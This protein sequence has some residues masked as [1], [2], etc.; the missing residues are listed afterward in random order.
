MKKTHSKSISLLS[1]SGLFIILFTVGLYAQETGKVKDILSIVAYDRL[2]TMPDTYLIDVRTRAEYQF[3]GHPE[4]AYLFPFKF[5]TTKLAKPGEEY[6]Y[7]FEEN[8]AFIEEISK[9]FKKEENLIII[10]RDGKRSALAAKELV[11]NGFEN[12]FNVKDGFEGR[13]FPFSED[14]PVED[15]YLKSLAKQNQIIGRKQRRHSGWQWWGLPWTY[16]MDPIY[17]YPPDVP[18]NISPQ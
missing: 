1:A 11:K 17:L 7:Q 13:E 2:Q 8:T 18:K 10:C 3:V 15:K 4:H 12:V 6:E 14:D 5:M 9:K 16:E